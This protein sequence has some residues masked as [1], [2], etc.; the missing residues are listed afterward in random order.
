MTPEFSSRRTSEP[1]MVR[2]LL[3]VS[4]PSQLMKAVA[5]VIWAQ[6][7]AFENYR[8]QL[9][10]WLAVCGVVLLTAG[11]YS[12]NDIA[13]VTTDRLSSIK[14]FRALANKRLSIRACKVWATFCVAG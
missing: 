13:D 7:C 1:S 10:A 6:F 5:V 11:F 9:D 3:A 12:I 2:N 4:R 8:S 14:R